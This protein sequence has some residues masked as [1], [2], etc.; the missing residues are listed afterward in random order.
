MVGRWSREVAH[1]LDAWSVVF[2]RV[3]HVNDAFGKVLG[4]AYPRHESCFFVDSI[5]QDGAGSEVVKVSE[6]A[7][8]GS[9]YHCDAESPDVILFYTILG[10]VLL[11]EVRTHQLRTYGTLQGDV[12]D[13]PFIARIFVG[14]KSVKID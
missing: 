14:L 6:I 4:I 11:D 12:L 5:K 3:E 7:Y 10:V 1:V 8:R 2:I 9:A 13:Y